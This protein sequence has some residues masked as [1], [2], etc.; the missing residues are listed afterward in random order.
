[1]ATLFVAGYCQISFVATANNRI[2]TL[3][4]DHLRGRVMSL[5]AQALIGVGPLGSTQAGALATLLGAPWAMAIGATVAGAVVLGIRI[6][7]PETFSLPSALSPGTGREE[8]LPASR[9]LWLRG[10]PRYH[11]P[12]PRSRSG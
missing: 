4:P 3:T 5:Y 11:P 8:G 1:M 12:P 7:R 10:R 6:L 2:Q 9:T